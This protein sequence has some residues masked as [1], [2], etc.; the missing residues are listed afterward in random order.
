MVVGAGKLR[1]FPL[2]FYVKLVCHVWAGALWQ[3][4][5]QICMMTRKKRR[6][7]RQ[8]ERYEHQLQIPAGLQVCSA[9]G[10]T[11]T[12]NMNENNIQLCDE[13]FAIMMR[14]DFPLRIRVRV[15]HC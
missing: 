7:E 11:N 5:D 13:I 4:S 3:V 14:S 1:S 12:S 2:F 9:S 10:F 8:T 15:L 6:H